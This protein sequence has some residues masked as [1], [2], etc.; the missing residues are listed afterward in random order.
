MVMYAVK[1]LNITPLK[2]RTESTLIQSADFKRDTIKNTPGLGA[3]CFVRWP[4]GAS[5]NEL[6]NGKG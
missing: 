6:E 4:E 5:N 1:R 2:I 3:C